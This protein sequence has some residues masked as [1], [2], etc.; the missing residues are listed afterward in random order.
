MGK[1]AFI[2]RIA[3]SYISIDCYSKDAV[4]MMFINSNVWPWYLPLLFK[5]KC[6]HCD[7]G[8]YCFSE[9]EVCMS[10]QVYV[11]LR[12]PSECQILLILQS[13][14]QSV[15]KK[16]IEQLNIINSINNVSHKNGSS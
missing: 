11:A 2:L 3:R 6:G 13:S 15:P 9:D 14:T 12:S 7:F 10:L 16:Y 5:M 8:T 1:V 4:L